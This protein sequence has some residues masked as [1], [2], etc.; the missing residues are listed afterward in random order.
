M[1][2]EGSYTPTSPCIDDFSL[3]EVEQSDL[4]RFITVAQRSVLTC[5][6]SAAAKISC[7]LKHFK[8]I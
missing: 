8:L 7:F 3:L 1:L 4:S 6:T 2:S 5:V